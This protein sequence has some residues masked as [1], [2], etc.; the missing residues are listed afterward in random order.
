MGFIYGIFI[1][2]YGIY[3]GFIYGIYTW[4]LYGIYIDLYGIYIWDL[5]GIY[6]YG[7]YIGSIWDLYGIYR[8]IWIYLGFLMMFIIEYGDVMGIYS[9]NKGI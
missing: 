4:D 8:F 6:I 5:Y 7:I 3:M 9:F 2:L 1:D